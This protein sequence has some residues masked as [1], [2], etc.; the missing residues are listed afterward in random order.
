MLSSVF[1][2]P[3]VNPEYG[4]LWVPETQF[5]NIPDGNYFLGAVVHDVNGNP[6]DLMQGEFTVDTSAPEADVEISAGANTVYYENA[7]GVYVATSLEP[8]AATLKVTG[9]PGLKTE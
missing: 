7:E 6:L 4:S 5:D 2:I 8:G 1:T 9:V 3:K